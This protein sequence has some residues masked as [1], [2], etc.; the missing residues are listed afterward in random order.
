MID[1]VDK[2][3]MPQRDVCTHPPCAGRFSPPIGKGKGL[4]GSIQST[5]PFPAPPVPKHLSDR[6]KE[7]QSYSNQ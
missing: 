4:C 7:N 3:S 1:M 5:H 2:N 6:G